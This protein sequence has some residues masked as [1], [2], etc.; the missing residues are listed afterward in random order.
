MIIPYTPKEE[1]SK[2]AN[3]FAVEILVKERKVD[4]TVFIDLFKQNFFTNGF[5]IM[6]EIKETCLKI[7]NYKNMLKCGKI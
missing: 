6:M 3:H 1:Y 2:I 5:H 4:P 7:G